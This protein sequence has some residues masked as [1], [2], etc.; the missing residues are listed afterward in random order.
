MKLLVVRRDNIGD[1]VLTT[2]ILRALR[3]RFPAARIEAFVNSYNAPVLSGHPDVDRVHAYTKA[4][5]L[6]A[7]AA[8]NW[9]GRLRQVLALRAA[10]FDHVIVATPGYQPRQVRFARWLAPAHIAA[11]VPPGARVPGVDLAVD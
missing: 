11:F 10:R 7:G 6:E 4:K 9:V 8:A 5:H 2:P 3:S 1:L